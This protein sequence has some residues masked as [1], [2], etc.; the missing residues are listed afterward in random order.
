MKKVKLPRLIGVDLIRTATN[1]KS[2]VIKLQVSLKFRIAFIFHSDNH[3]QVQ[4]L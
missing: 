3:E 4:L 1:W 2:F